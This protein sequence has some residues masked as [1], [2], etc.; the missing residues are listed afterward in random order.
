[1]KTVLL[2]SGAVFLCG[3][4]GDLNTPSR[5]YG[6]DRVGAVASDS[7]RV[8]RVKTVSRFAGRFF[9]VGVMLAK[10]VGLVYD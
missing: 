1:M 4:C 10:K 5:R 6:L 7:E 2:F 8:V 9:C 3:D